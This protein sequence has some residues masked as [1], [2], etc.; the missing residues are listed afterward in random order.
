M[1][2]AARVATFWACAVAAAAQLGQAGAACIYLAGRPGELEAPLRGAGVK[3]F[4]FAGG[5]AL[6]TLRKAYELMEQA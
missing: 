6:A 4:V 3:E 1:R 2:R 5:D